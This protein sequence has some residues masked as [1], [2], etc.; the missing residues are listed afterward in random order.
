MFMTPEEKKEIDDTL[1]V[2]KKILIVMTILSV[3]LI[4]Y[5]TIFIID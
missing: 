5:A 2:A 3:A 4:T 1:R